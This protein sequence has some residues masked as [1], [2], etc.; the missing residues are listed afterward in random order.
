VQL[1]LTSA[2]GLDEIRFDAESSLQAITE[3]MMKEHDLAPTVS[4]RL[5]H[6]QIGIGDERCTRAVELV[7]DPSGQRGSGLLVADA[8]QQRVTRFV[9]KFVVYQFEVVEVDEQHRHWL[10][11]MRLRVI[12]Q[13]LSVREAGEAVTGDLVYQ[14]G[15]EI[16]ALCGV[17]NRRNGAGNALAIMNWTDAALTDDFLAIQRGGPQVVIAGKPLGDGIADR[18]DAE[19]SILDPRG[20]A[21][22]P[23]RCRRDLR[24][25]RRSICLP[26]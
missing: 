17:D 15:L 4:F 6:S 14:L 25:G 26:G 5:V 12:L 13:R 2:G 21:S 22:C 1:K 7:S 24:S 8:Q 11:G 16:V 23:F 9:S 19:A 10:S 18:L 3:V 20:G